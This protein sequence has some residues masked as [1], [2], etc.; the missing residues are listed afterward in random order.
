MNENVI[1]LINAQVQKEI[2]SAYFY[3]AVA[4]FYSENG[5]NGFANWFRV[6]TKEELTHAEKFCEFLHNNNCKVEMFSI[7]A[8]DIEIKDIKEPLVFALKQEKYITESINKIYR[9]AEEREDLRTINFLQWFIK[10]QLEEEV[11]A[12]NLIEKM[13]FVTDDICGLYLL[14]KEMGIRR[15]VE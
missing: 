4:N 3:F 8:L 2:E 15:F 9:E 6:Q 11:A 10:E 12:R 13:E 7:K 1:D 5:L 14:D